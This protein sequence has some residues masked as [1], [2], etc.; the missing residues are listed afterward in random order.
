MHEHA[1][2][3]V[4]QPLSVVESHLWDVGS[5]PTFLGRLDSAVRTTHERYSV[6][7]RYGWHDEEAVIRVRWRARDHK[8]TWRTEQGP[9]WCGEFSLGA[10]NKSRTVITLT[11]SLGTRF[12][13]WMLR[14]FS[15]RDR[16]AAADLERLRQRLELLPR[17]T[18]LPTARPRSGAALND[19]AE[20]H[21]IR[22][23]ADRGE[24]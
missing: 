10:V 22:G 2:T 16:S 8:V 24:P 11:T 15:G 1:T 21:R 6:L 20:A 23:S 13:G 3:V 9:V 4:S 7:F 12:S 18:R 5:W 19:L 17:P 14:W